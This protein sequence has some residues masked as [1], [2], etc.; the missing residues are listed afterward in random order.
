MRW[1]G[2]LPGDR[3]V[4]PGVPTVKVARY[5]EGRLYVTPG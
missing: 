3:A 1:Q 5:A 2:P 4:N